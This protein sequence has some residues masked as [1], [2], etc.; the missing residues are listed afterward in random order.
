MVKCLSLHRGRRVR[1][2]DKNRKFFGYPLLLFFLWNTEGFE[3]ISREWLI[4]FC[5]LA[6]GRSFFIKASR[7]QVLRFSDALSTCPCSTLPNQYCCNFLD[8]PLQQDSICLIEISREI[9]F[10]LHWLETELLHNWLNIS[11]CVL[12]FAWRIYPNMPSQVLG[13]A[14]G[15]N[16]LVSSK[17]WSLSPHRGVR[18]NNLCL[19]SCNQAFRREKMWNSQQRL[20]SRWN[21]VTRTVNLTPYLPECQ[22]DTFGAQSLYSCQ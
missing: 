2:W 8:H 12:G 13:N 15:L 18:E 19:R 9:F 17:A 16:K 6:P 10:L 4:A 7:S 3:E 5:E 1:Y 22:S 21:P 20:Q 14:R 11:S